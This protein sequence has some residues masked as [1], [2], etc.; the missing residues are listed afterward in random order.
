M[1]VTKEIFIEGNL[2]ENSRVKIYYKGKFTR[3]FSTDVYILYGYGLGWKNIKEQRM[4]WNG[5]CFTIELDLTSNGILNFCFKNNFGSWDNNYGNDYSVTVKEE[6]KVAV[7]PEDKREVGMDVSNVIEE[8]TSAPI[9]EDRIP[10]VFVEKTIVDDVPTI[11]PEVVVDFVKEERKVEIPEVVKEEIKEEIKPQEE[12]KEEV[13]EEKPVYEAKHILKKEKVKKTFEK[14][15][16]KDKKKKKDKNKNK[17][18]NNNV[19]TRIPYDDKEESLFDYIKNQKNENDYSIDIRSI[20]EAERNEYQTEK[21]PEVKVQDKKSR[22]AKRRERN[23]RRK[24]LRIFFLIVLIITISYIVINFMM[25]KGVEKETETLWDKVT[26]TVNEKVKENERLSKLKSLRKEHPDMKAWIE[27]PDTDISYPVMQGTDNDYYVKH[28]YK[29]EKSKWGALFV[30]KAY[31][32]EK[33]S[34][35]IL[36]YGH[37]FTDG[38]MF[39]DLI[40]YKDKE[41]YEAHKTIKFTTAEEDA[42]Y[43]IISV[44]N[45]RVYYTHEENVFRYYFFVDAKNEQEYNDYVNNAK[46]VSLHKIDATAEYGDQLLTLSTCDYIQEDG[47]FVVVARKIVNEEK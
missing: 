28:D 4:D 13:K 10:E 9:V 1:E 36:I 18:E 16:K 25:A 12:I 17:Y 32:W 47:R 8:V 38:L 29:G 33:P 24:G 3:E 5:E 27:I 31:D 37:N 46:K 19:V 26:T 45:S 44:F 21:K 43:E 14:K 11:I 15:D 39:A 7:V 30:D 6:V 41:F 34:S 23:K 40:K 35:N 20:L 22:R 2:I 42:E